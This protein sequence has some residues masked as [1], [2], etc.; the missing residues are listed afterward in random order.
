MI[1]TLGYILFALMVPLNKIGLW[2]GYMK[3]YG[4]DYLLL[5]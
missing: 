2:S 3:K 1:S 4:S 5:H